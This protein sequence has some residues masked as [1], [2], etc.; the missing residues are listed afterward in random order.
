MSQGTGT[1]NVITK[2]TNGNL[3]RQVLVTDGVAGIVGTAALAANIG[4]VVTVYSLSDAES[5][6]YTLTDEP[7]LHRHILEFYNELGGSQELWILGTEDTMTMESACTSTNPNGVRKLLTI[8]KGRVNL[9]GICRKPADSYDA[10]TGFLD[11]DVQNAL[12]TSKV[13]G[14]YQQSINRPVRFLIEGRIKD[15]TVIPIFKPVSAEN[16]FAGIVLGGTKNDNS[17]SVAVALARAVKYPAHIKLGDGT[18]GVLSITSA[19]IGSKSVD[20]FDPVELNNFTDAGYIHYHTR[21]GISGYFFSVDKMSG[22]DDFRILVYGRLIDKAQRVATSSSIP[23]LESSVRMTKEGKINDADAAY[24][25]QNIKSQLLLQMAGQISDADVLVPTDQDLINTNTLEMQ[26]K[27][28]PLG[29]LT[30]IIL[31]LGLT[32]TI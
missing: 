31:N 11:I 12:V 13:L 15:E 4:K 18:N 16:T 3:Q 27:I 6:G 1:P 20:E 30:W 26:V 9:V 24:L 7:F 22:N 23:F 8:S 10:G 25:E 2:V 29:Y 14:Q 17:A 21:E 32:K 5:K 28:Q 19:F